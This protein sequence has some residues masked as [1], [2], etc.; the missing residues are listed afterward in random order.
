MEQDKS[1][2]EVIMEKIEQYDIIK[3]SLSLAKLAA[4]ADQITEAKILYDNILKLEPE[5]KVAIEELTNLE[6]S[7]LQNK[8]EEK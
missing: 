7:Q 8:V 5:N 1:K 2:H 6:K 3:K 4:K